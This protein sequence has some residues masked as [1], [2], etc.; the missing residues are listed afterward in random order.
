MCSLFRRYACFLLFLYAVAA[1]AETKP[2]VFCADPSN[3]PFSTRGRTGFEN[4]IAAVLAHEMKMDVRFYWARMGRG[5]L[6]NVLNKGECDALLGVP[7]GMRGLLLTRPYYR[8]SYVFVTRENAQPLSSFDD[9]RLNSMRIGVQVLDDDYAPPARALARRGLARNIVGFE[10][11][12]KPGAIVS[13]VAE[14]KLDVA[15]VWGPVAGFYAHQVATT[16]GKKLRLS[17]ILP[18]VDPPALP[19]AYDLAAGVRKNA[20]NLQRGLDQAIV[21]ARPKIEAILRQYH[22]P[23]LS[24]ENLLASK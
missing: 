5:F 18:S 10:M 2:L 20:P 15:V 21:R 11:E 9:P 7:I 14:G 8:S 12:E 1:N 3:V 4:R 17:P 16:S 23:L 19:F 6:R 24:Q 22:V 13:S